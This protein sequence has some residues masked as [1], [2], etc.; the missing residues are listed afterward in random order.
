MLRQHSLQIQAEPKIGYHQEEFGG[1]SEEDKEPD[2]TGVGGPKELEERI[3]YPA[4]AVG[5][6]V[7]GAVYARVVLNDERRVAEVKITGRLGGGCDEEVLKA[8]TAYK[9]YE[10][11][12]RPPLKK[13]ESA[14]VP[15]IVQFVLPAK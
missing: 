14:T 1:T 3:S 2:G 10:E 11:S 13:G 9:F 7:E 5:R 6:N 4:E 12:G 8:L 15:I